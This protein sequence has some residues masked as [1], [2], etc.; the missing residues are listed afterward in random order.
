[1][2]VCVSLSVWY[3]ILEHED[4]NV[5]AEQ[6]WRVLIATIKIPIHI[7]QSNFSFHVQTSLKHTIICDRTWEKGPCR[8]SFQNRVITT[9][10]KSR[11]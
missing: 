11:L 10:G 7:S 4:K 2:C 6:I 9:I 8:A 3:V 5:R 1:M